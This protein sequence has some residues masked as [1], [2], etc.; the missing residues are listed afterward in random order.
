MV[1]KFEKRL[2]MTTETKARWKKRLRGALT[3]SGCLC[4]PIVPFY[5]AFVVQ[6]LWNWFVA[7]AIHG[8]DISYWQSF[9]A[10]LIISILTNNAEPS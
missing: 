1:S 10:L 3:A 7:S 5:T 2:A 6:N 9:G 4:M 8:E